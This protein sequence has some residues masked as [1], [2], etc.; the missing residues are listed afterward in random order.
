[1]ATEC[2]LIKPIS[3][4]LKDEDCQNIA[5]L[6]LGTAMRDKRLIRSALMEMLDPKR[7]DS[8][9]LE[10]LISV[11]LN[12]DENEEAIKAFCAKIDIDGKLVL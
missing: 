11:L 12:D 4:S 2:K 6:L 1:M 9:I 3:N 5:E 8:E 10:G 7:G